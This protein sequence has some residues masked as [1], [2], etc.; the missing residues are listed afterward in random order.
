MALVE[1]TRKRVGAGTKDAPPVK[2]QG[3]NLKDVPSDVVKEVLD[4]LGGNTEDNQKLVKE[5]VARGFNHY[6]FMKASDPFFGK[7][8]AN[9]SD[10]EEA[11]WR[12]TARNL[13]KMGKSVDDICKILP[14]A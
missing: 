1:L 7:V 9:L 2:Y 10:A 13:L 12:Q 5:F 4:S 11:T 3:F 8:P 6:Q 14:S